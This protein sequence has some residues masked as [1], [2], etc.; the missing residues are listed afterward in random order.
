MLNGVDVRSTMVDGFDAGR[1]S[2]FTRPSI[3]GKLVAIS[4]HVLS[5]GSPWILHDVLI[6]NPTLSSMLCKNSSSGILI[7]R[8]GKEKWR[9]IG[10]VGFFSTIMVS[11]AG[12][13]LETNSNISSEGLT[14]WDKL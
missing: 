7:A 2:R 14:R 5:G 4:C 11:G 1:L 10:A 9:D 6:I 3:D 12:E 13:F 8:V